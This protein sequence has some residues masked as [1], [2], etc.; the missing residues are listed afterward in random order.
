MKQIGY[1][2][3]KGTYSQSAFQ[4]YQAHTDDVLEEKISQDISSLFTWIQSSSDVDEIIVPV[5]NSIEGAVSQTLDLLVNSNGLSLKREIIIEVSHCLMAK[6]N[7]PKTEITNVLSHPQALGQCQHYLSKQIPKA[8]HVVTPSTAMAA[9]IVQE[10]SMTFSD[11]ETH[12]LAAIGSKDLAEIYELEILEKNINDFKENRTRFFVVSKNFTE[13]SGEDKTS[14]IFST[15]K[16]KPGGLYE[17]LGAFA[18]RNINL[19][20]ISSRPAKTMLG[21]YVFFKIGRAHV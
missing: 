1:L 7:V 11:N 16:D 17:A 5:E 9:K 21:E 2:G 20:R 13:P 6:N 12:V 14:I 8:K 18:K 3:P 10:N 15:K 19:T 4:K